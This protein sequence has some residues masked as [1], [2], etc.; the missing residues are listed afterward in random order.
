MSPE[1]APSVNY[2]RSTAVPCSG[3]TDQQGPLTCGSRM[4]VTVVLD[5][6]YFFPDLYANF[7]KIYL[8]L[9]ASYLC[10]PNFVGFH[11]KCS[12]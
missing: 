6:V 12:I 8:G 7:G 10:E 2:R 1:V 5:L 3:V 11:I 9:G 4:S